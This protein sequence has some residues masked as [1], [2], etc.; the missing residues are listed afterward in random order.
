M[1]APA[2]GSGFCVETQMSKHAP[3]VTR[4]DVVGG[5][6]MA[7]IGV[8]APSTLWAANGPSLI[9]RQIPSTKELIPAIGIGTN[10]FGRT[11]QTDVREVLKRMQ[12]LGGTVIDTAAE[13]GESETEIGNA[14]AEL[15]ITNDMFIATKFNAAG[16]TFGPPPGMGASAGPA[17]T[18]LAN[19]PPTSRVEDGGPP[20]DSV[21]GRDS[22]E[23]SIKRLR[24]I[25][26]LFAHHLGSWEPMMPIMMELKKQ[27]RIRYIGI[28]SVVS[29]EIPQVLEFMRA[30]PIDFLQISYSLAQRD[31]EAEVL[32]LARERQVAVMAAMPL[33]GGRNSLLNQAAGRTLPSWA[34][35]FDAA[36]WSQFFLKYVIS[37][38]AVTCA[39]P[40]S[41][42]V[43]H[44]ED[45]QAAGRGRLP[46]AAMRK[47]IE[48]FW[49][50]KA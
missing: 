31:V 21:S 7:G 26:L 20:S 47:R 24:K 2:K 14:L 19:S 5:G 42:K 28:T 33:G 18:N 48:N 37:H 41:T 30:H 49:I 46:T 27:G 45:N 32:P 43:L 39:I 13:Y 23:R 22:F 17:A 4:R 8:V 50:G 11:D 10:Q 40:G 6:L 35:D 15:G 29:S 36:S 12:E 38:P 25:D 1:E 34:A 44:L 9:K 16:V 3:K